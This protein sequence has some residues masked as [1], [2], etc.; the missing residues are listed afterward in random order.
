MQAATHRPDS[1]H[2][3]IGV[4]NH[5]AEQVSRRPGEL[6]G[7]LAIPG[8]LRDSLQLPPGDKVVFCSDGETLVYSLGGSAN[9]RIV[10][11]SAGRR[12]VVEAP[13]RSFAGPL[14]PSIK[15]EASLSREIEAA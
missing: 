11:H 6:T 4:A 10:T 9:A 12:V 15:A 1:T 2:M 13:H 5:G 14:P 3:R 8:A 7:R